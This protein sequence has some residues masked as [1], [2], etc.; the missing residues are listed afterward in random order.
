MGIKISELFYYRWRYFIGYGL[1]SIGLVIVLFFVGMYSPGGITNQEMQSVIHSSS[2]DI[3]NFSPH[4]IVNLPYY[5]LQSLFLLIFG[6]STISI[7]LASIVLALITAIGVIILLR[8]WFSPG[9]G[10]LASL[11]AITTS[12]FL[13]I[14]QDGTPGILYILWPVWTLLLASFIAR[15]S[16]HQTL[17]KILLFATIAFSLYTPLSIYVILALIIATTLHPHLRFLIGQLSR[18]K[19]LIGLTT[20]VI[21]LLPLI[22]AII[23]SPALVLELLGIPQ[24][25]PDILANLSLLSTQYFSFSN[26]GQSVLPTP[27]FGLGSIL[28]I[29]FGLAN[30]LRNRSNAKS[31]VILSW[32]GLLIPIVILNPGDIS[33]TYLPLVLLLASGLRAILSYWYGLFPLNPYARI[34]GLIPIMVLIFVLVSSGVD[35]N[36]YGYR[37]DPIVAPSFS[38]DLSLLPTGTNNLVVTQNELA[39]YQAVS[40]YNQDISISTSPVGDS[41][42]ATRDAKND[43]NGYKISRIITNSNSINADRFYVYQK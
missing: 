20:A 35:R 22:W 33:I 21:L 31:Y 8:R 9:I 32:I 40:K 3:S 29:A 24:S 23:K 7:K 6:V 25:M 34:A 4:D 11:I 27:F 17:Y 41:F 16:R 39:F 15:K 43:Y 12:Q 28:I 13:F 2:I 5:Y 37:Y 14:A 1:V 19:I 38:K 36:I 26:P 18:I 10:V 42:T 30:I